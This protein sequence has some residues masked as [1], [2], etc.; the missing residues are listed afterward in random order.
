MAGTYQELLIS[1]A[2]KVYNS[3]CGQTLVD[4]FLK[5]HLFG[6]CCQLCCSALDRDREFQRYFPTVRE[7]IEVE[8]WLLDFLQQETLPQK[9][10]KKIIVW[11]NY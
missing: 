7:R 5:E 4:I 1:E 10:L 9:R 11:L 2:T 3:N 8:S 6:T